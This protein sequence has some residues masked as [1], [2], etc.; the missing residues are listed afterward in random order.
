MQDKRITSLVADEQYYVGDLS[1]FK[2]MQWMLSQNLLWMLLVTVCGLA[3]VSLLLFV[4]LRSR[5]RKRLS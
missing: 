4:F 5:A 2:R 3:L 1:L